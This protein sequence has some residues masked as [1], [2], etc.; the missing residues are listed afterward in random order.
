MFTL[1]IPCFKQRS[2]I[3]RL[4]LFQTPNTRD[5]KECDLLCYRLYVTF[6]FQRSYDY[7]LK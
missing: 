4:L 7:S 1:L 6:T 2:A 3:P 5:S